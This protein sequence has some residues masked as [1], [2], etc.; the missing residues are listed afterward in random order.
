MY[1]G[2]TLYN[3]TSEESH[4]EEVKASG[5]EITSCRWSDVPCLLWTTAIDHSNSESTLWMSDGNIR[6]RVNASHSLS[7]M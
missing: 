5:I 2:N 7:S 6:V 4:E 3:Q 1:V